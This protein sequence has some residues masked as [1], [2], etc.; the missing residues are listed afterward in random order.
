MYNATFC[1]EPAPALIACDAADAATGVT[2]VLIDTDK[3]KAMGKAP[4]PHPT[5]IHGALR[6]A[7]CVC[8]P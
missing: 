8:M 5:R 3:E 7:A 4:H 1:M 2:L 6:C